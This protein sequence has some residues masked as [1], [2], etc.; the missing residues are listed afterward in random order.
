[1][2][3]ET[4]LAQLIN[5]EVMADMISAELPNA[6]QV[7]RFY[8]VDRTLVA[9]AGNTITVPKWSYVGEATDL[10]E[11]VEGTVTQMSSS[12]VEYTVKK[13]VKNIVLTDEAVLSGYGDPI[14]EARN[15]LRMAIADKVDSDGIAL[16]EALTA[17]PNSSATANLSYNMIVD[18]LDDF[19]DEEQGGEKIILVN[20]TGIKQ[21]RKD[22]KFIDKYNE[23]SQ[24]AMVSG[25]VGKIAGCDVV[26]SNKIADKAGVSYA[27]IMK[28]RAITA[29][30]KRDVSVETERDVLKK[31]TIISSDEHY[32][33]AIEDESKIVK[34]QFKKAV[35]ST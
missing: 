33:C 13:A 14:G 15:Q 11:G 34:V 1:M 29:F 5:P 18:C 27:Y 24:E 17:S 8:K 4:K 22:E 19:A 26:I 28:P 2:A 21:L 3:N 23:L 30:L 35:S 7:S 31:Q 16:L 9:K 32:V 25:V 12:E 20:K 6:L 10:E